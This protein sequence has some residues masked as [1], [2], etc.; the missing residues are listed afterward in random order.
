[1][2][3]ANNNNGTS[4]AFDLFYV[5]EGDRPAGA[6]AYAVAKGNNVSI[7]D[8]GPNGTVLIPSG[9]APGEAVSLDGLNWRA[10]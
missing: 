6:G 2:A 7:V 8:V 4:P 1:M 10:G 5:P 9:I 3:S